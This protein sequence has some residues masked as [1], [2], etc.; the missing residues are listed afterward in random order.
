MFSHAKTNYTKKG[1]ECPKE[2]LFKFGECI[3]VVANQVIRWYARQS[4][5]YIIK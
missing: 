3:K 2:Q 5:T 4:N 1:M